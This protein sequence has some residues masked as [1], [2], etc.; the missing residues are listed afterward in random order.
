M[1]RN[2]R[3]ISKPGPARTLLVQV[4][5]GL[6][7]R[8]QAAD[9]LMEL[10]RLSETAG[11][12]VVGRITQ[13]RPRF[14]PS[15]CVGEG[16]LSEI[17]LA[18]HESRASLVVFD[19]ELT[20]SQVNNLDLSLGIK[21]ID[22]TELILEIFARRARSSEAKVQVELAQLQYLITR[23]PVSAK[24]HR[25]DGG[26]GMRGP[27]ESPFQLRAAPM[28]KRIQELKHK[29][30]EVRKRRERTRLRR[31]WPT[32]CLVGYTN[33]G[34]STLMN[35]F[36]DAD[37]YVDDR[38]FATL[39]TKTRLMLLPNMRKVLITDTVG[40]IRHLPHG[41]VASFHST[42]QEVADADMLLVMVDASH[43]HVYNHIDVVR[44]TLK[45]IGAE[46]VP[47]LLLLNKIDTPQAQAAIPRLLAMHPDAIACSA[48]SSLGL[49]QVMDKM[50]SM[51]P[52][53]PEPSVDSPLPPA[54]SET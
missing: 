42:L 11:L 4:T 39:D 18:C 10:E 47:S 8:E 45:E 2:S 28:K 16:K 14:S 37:A 7:D 54:P 53:L 30:E 48:R 49:N 6:Q 46:R 32:V 25:F 21:V 26:I 24:Q 27:G 36:T 3:L 52:P 41:L 44:E 9:S 13:H 35:A 29:L 23:I 31:L 33:A 43:P 38:L 19:N 22:H 40:F 12:E 17:K 15:F 51:M 5:T 20:P 50:E 34:K 1:T